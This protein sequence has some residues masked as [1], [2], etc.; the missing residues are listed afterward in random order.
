MIEPIGHRERV[1]DVGADRAHGI[2]CRRPIPSSAHRARTETEDAAPAP[3]R[4]EID[5]GED[6]G[7]QGTC[8]L[9]TL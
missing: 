1:A 5:D 2:S 9:A 4:V 7:V 3:R 6:D 8:R